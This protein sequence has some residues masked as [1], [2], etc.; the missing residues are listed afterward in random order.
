M[1]TTAAT[2][3][4]SGCNI[5]NLKSDLDTYNTAQSTTD[6]ELKIYMTAQAAFQKAN[7]GQTA[8]KKVFLM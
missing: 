8:T 7:D 2:G 5:T 1:G 6:T 3:Q 4:P